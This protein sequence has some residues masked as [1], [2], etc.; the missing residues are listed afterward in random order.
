MSDIAKDA[1]AWPFQEAMK[2]VKRFESGPPEKGFA[3]FETGYGSSGL[4]HIGTF[5]EVARTTMVRKAFG[6]LSDIPTRLYC[7]ADDMDGLRKVPDNIPNRDMVAKHLGKP[8]TKVPDPFGEFESFGEHNNVRMREFLDTFGFDYEFYSST[9][10]YHSGRFD[11]ALLRVLEVYDKILNVILPTLGEERRQS[12][13]PFLPICPKTGVV[14]QVPLKAHD[15][16]AG[17]ITFD[18]STGEEHTVSVKGGTCKLQWKV[19]WAMRWYAFNVDYEMSGKDLIESVKLSSIICRIMGTAPPETF[20]FELFLDEHG[21]K[22]S[23]SKGNGLTLEEWLRY[24]SPDSL[25][26]YM[27]Q[28]PTRAKRLYFDVIPKAVD[29]YFTFLEKYPDQDDAAKLENPVHHIHG[30]Q[31]PGTDMPI[32]FALL[33]NLVGTA[34]TSDKALLWKFISRYQSGTGPETHPDL[35]RLIGF[36]VRYYEDFIAPTRKQRKP[37]EQ[38]TR[39]LLDLKSGL[40]KLADDA[41]A[42]DFQTLVFDI[43]KKYNYENLREWFQALYEIL[44]GQPQGPRMGTFIK[45]FGRSEMSALID[46]VTGQGK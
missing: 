23:K 13:S 7:F 4:P 30:G 14:L 39:A 8:V 24:A 27:F 35:D 5:G 42:D 29:E 6:Q 45:L 32:T 19:D 38:E 40:S 28:N 37:T 44:F 33:I 3:L 20:I 18:D 16:K 36:A 34:Q 15:T 1:K 41:P 2:L 22:I 11:A 26:L 25:S 10:C 9:E 46:Q 17:T 21:E 12:Y 43:G 31:V